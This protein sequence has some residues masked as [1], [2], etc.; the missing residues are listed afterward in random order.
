MSFFLG[1]K[2]V[3]LML[4]RIEVLVLGIITI[5]ISLF[6]REIYEIVIYYL[7]ITVC[8]ACFGL[9]I[10]VLLTNYYGRDKVNSIVMIK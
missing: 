5:I 1:R 6:M 10:L 2:N 8:E 3:L 7:V 4:L 9:L